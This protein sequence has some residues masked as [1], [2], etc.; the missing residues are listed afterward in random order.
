MDDFTLARMLHVIAVLLW[1]GGVG[2]VTLVV[3]PSIRA[4][5]APGQRLAAFHRVEGRFARQAALWVALAG[6]SGLWMLYRGDLWAL[7]L[8]PR[9]WW[10]HAMV[11]VWT[12]F[13]A[14]IFVLEPL[15]LHRRMAAS[16]DPARDYA[17]VERLHRVLLAASLVTVAGAVGGAHGLF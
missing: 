17:R 4:D 7:F 10:L 15:A 3:M 1:I 14:M 11:L 2:F 8:D 12:L 5:H 9:A 16:P 13:A 6:L